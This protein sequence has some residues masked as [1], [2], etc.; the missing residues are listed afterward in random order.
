MPATNTYRRVLQQEL[1]HR[2]QPFNIHCLIKRTSRQESTYNGGGG[3]QNIE[4]D[5]IIVQR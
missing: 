3:G 5:C 2:F 1:L 4:K